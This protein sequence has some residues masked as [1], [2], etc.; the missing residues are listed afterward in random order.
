MLLVFALPPCSILKAMTRTRHSQ[1]CKLMFLHAS[2]QPIGPCMRFAPYMQRQQAKRTCTHRRTP[3]RPARQQPAGWYAS[4]W[5]AISQLY[6][7]R[8]RH[9]GSC[10]MGTRG[11]RWAIRRLWCGAGTKAEAPRKVRH[12]CNCVTPWSTNL[13]YDA[14]VV[15]GCPPMDFLMSCCAPTSLPSVGHR[16]PSRVGAQLGG[17]G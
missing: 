11:R 14:L 15:M 5:Q 12:Y 13:L 4:Q 6:T 16:W 8:D 1:G 10:V 17:S 2:Q 3:C 9:S 7:E